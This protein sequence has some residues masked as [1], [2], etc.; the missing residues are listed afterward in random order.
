MSVNDY[1]NPGDTLEVRVPIGAFAG[2]PDFEQPICRWS[3]T[4]CV[5]SGFTCVS[6]PA[7]SSGTTYATNAIV[8]SSGLIY[9]SLQD[10]NLNHAPATEITWWALFGAGSHFPCSC[11][12]SPDFCLDTTLLDLADVPGI[13]TYTDTARSCGS[14]TYDTSW[15]ITFE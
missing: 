5:T 7:W 9:I 11:S 10:G 2:A 12:D 4:P 8:N 1:P 14:L 13:H 6:P 3:V 15:T